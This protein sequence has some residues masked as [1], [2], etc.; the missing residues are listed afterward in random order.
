MYCIYHFLFLGGLFCFCPR[1]IRSPSSVSSVE[2]DRHLVILQ[3][4]GPQPEKSFEVLTFPFSPLSALRKHH[5][6][7]DILVR[8]GNK[9]SFLLDQLVFFSMSLLG[10]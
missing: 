3:I 4:Y 6:Y 7:I 5:K 8:V 2:N 1:Q 10:P 9:L